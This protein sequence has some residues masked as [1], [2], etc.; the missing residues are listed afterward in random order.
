MCG[1]QAWAREWVDATGRYRVEAELVSLRG[2]KV[3]L[4]KSDG[5]IITLPIDRLSLADQNYLKSLSQPQTASPAP[6]AASSVPAAAPM[7]RNA[8]GSLAPMSNSSS[9]TAPPSGDKL[10]LAEQAQTILQAAC[11]R[12]HG[13]DGASEGGF[14]FVVNLEKLSRTIAKPGNAAQ[15]Q[16]YQRMTASDD[17]QMPPVG[18]EPRPT[19]EQLATIKAWIEA[20]SPSLPTTQKRPFIT[21]EQ[22][23]D[24]IYADVQKQPERSRRFMRYF[25][26]T[27]LYNAGVSEDE[28]QTYRNAFT[29][30]INS[31]SWNTSLISPRPIDSARTVMGIDI[32]DLFWNV[33]MWAAIEKANPYFLR[34]TTPSSIKCVEETQTEMPLVRIDWFVFAA[35]KPPLYHVLLNLPDSDTGLEDLLR[36]N[37]Q[38]NIDQE[39]A[40][41]AAFNRS[42]VSQNNR[43][44]EWHKS[45][46]GS[47]WKSYDFGGSA[48][49]Q[50]LFQYPMGPH[51]N[52]DTF[53]HDGG[54][55]IF[56]LPNGL[57]GYLLVDG[58]GKRIDQGPINIVSD[59]KRADKTVTNGVSCMSCHYTGVIPKRD[60][61]GGAVR[62]NR[63]AFADA[64][65]ILALYRE[66]A[67]LDEI[68]SHD[69]QRFAAAS[70]RI[71]ISSLSRSGEPVSAMAARFEQEIDLPQVAC[72]FGLSAE[73]FRE[74]L[75]KA[76]TVARA[77]SSLLIPGGTIK[78]DV[79]KDLFA[80]ASIDLRLVT[81]A[82]LKRAARHEFAAPRTT[83]TSP[84]RSRNAMADDAAEGAEVAVFRDLKW[85]ATSLAFSSD[86]NFLA[87][88]TM[89]RTIVLFDVANRAQAGSIE[90]L[91]LLGKVSQCV[92]TPDGD[93]LVV[94]GA[95]GQI[96]VYAVSPEGLL[97][98]VSQFAGHSKEITAL[99]V[100][101]DGE[102]VLSGSEDKK[103]CHWEIGSGSQLATL[104]EF[105]G[106][107]K[108]VHL[109]RNGRTAQATDGAVL[110][111]YDLFKKE[112]KRRR[113][114]ARSWASG[115]AAAFAA[116]G[117][118]LAVGDGQNIRLWNLESGRELPP[119]VGNELQ[120]TMQFTPDGTRLLSGG[121]S[122][123]SVWDTK[124]IQRIHVQA[125]GDSG[126]VQSLAVS[127][128][129]KLMAA[130]GSSARDVHIFK[131]KGVR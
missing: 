110:I 55:I 77:F 94:G 42:G 98:E 18:E 114:L 41:R 29:K 75:G 31:L 53:Q 47:Y 103:V 33:E 122:K 35:S 43:L 90:K 115:Q 20:G 40:I 58:S 92:F 86:A 52:G 83:S 107:I 109:S 30:L 8:A 15:S 21:N 106:K 131:V 71:G 56:S 99:A 74:R 12:C 5:N 2:D 19:A 62:A 36:V 81:T 130:P 38:A 72:E 49:R 100:S 59:P 80:E 120:W 79:F 129:G 84:A 14:N 17:S 111:E 63:G 121:S 25:T 97:K 13:E 46:Y 48:G 28:L 60:E 61:V 87:T 119:L 16:L 104:P 69:S 89:D 10:A 11:Y 105:Q 93:H 27:H 95:T 117:E 9:P 66:A 73:D 112:L 127:G 64:E 118:M 125:I 34:L 113:A 68:F 45:P 116:D 102:H 22:I 108:A 128:D 126:Y 124:K 6:A 32:R 88:G 70:K 50:N 7:A 37:V 3:I 76:T 51:G 123:V 39:Q 101:P 44:I 57:Q 78:R 24:A 85:G 23:I 26:L 82:G 91:D 65:D 96:I 1:Q 67:E 4:E 54:E